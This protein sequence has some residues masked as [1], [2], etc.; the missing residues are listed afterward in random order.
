L[1]QLRRGLAAPSWSAS[2]A[3][4]AVLIIG[5]ENPICQHANVSNFIITEERQVLAGGLIE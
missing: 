3:P 5:A 1:A 4:L 2:E